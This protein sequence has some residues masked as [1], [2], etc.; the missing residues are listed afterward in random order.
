MLAFEVKAAE[1]VAGGDFKALRTLRDALG[2]RFIAGIALSTGHRSYTYEDRLHVM[3]IDRLWRANGMTANSR[4]SR[5]AEGLKSRA[6]V[7]DTAP[8]RVDGERVIG[9]RRET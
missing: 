3:P 4:A 2:S 9:G 6:L 7:G 8:H 5:P 1:R